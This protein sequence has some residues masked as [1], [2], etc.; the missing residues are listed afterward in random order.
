MIVPTLFEKYPGVEA[1]ADADVADI[2]EIVRPC[3]L[4]K[5]KAQRYQ[6][7]HENAPGRV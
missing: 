5:S 7:L 1:L 4:G 3:G 2:E 6:C